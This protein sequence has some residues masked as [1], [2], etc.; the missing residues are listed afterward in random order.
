V[1]HTIPRVGLEVLFNL[2][3]DGLGLQV[4]II[5]ILELNELVVLKGLSGSISAIS[6]V[7]NSSLSVDHAIELLNNVLFFKL[8]VLKILIKDV[9]SLDVVSIMNQNFFSI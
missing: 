1:D 6:W 5:D 2:F 7:I 4:I 3:L 9:S 8:S